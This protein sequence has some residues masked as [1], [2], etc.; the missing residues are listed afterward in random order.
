MRIIKQKRTV[1]PIKMVGSTV[2]GRYPKISKE[3]TFNMIISDGWLVPY[4]GHKKVAEIIEGGEARGL[5]NSIPLGKMVIVIDN[6]IYFYSKD[7]ALEFRGNID[8]YTSDVFIAENDANQIAICD[9]KDI[10][11]LDYKN[12]TFSKAYT[13]PETTLDFVPNYITFQ[14]GYFIAAEATRSRWRLSKINDGREFPAGAPYEGAFQSKSDIPLAVVSVPGKGNQIF[15]MGSSVTEAWVDTGAALF[16]YQK[17]TAFN[18]DYGCVNQTTIAAS[19]DFIV[20]VGINEK[21]GLAILYS[22]GGSVRQISNDGINFKLAELTNPADCYAFLFKQ[23]GHLLYQAVWRTDNISYV[24]DFNTEAFFTLTDYNYSHHIAKRVTFF[25]N[26]YYFISF[27][28]GALYELSSNYTDYDGKQIPRVRITPTIR[29]P[30]DSSFIGDYLTF[31]A[32]QGKNSELSAIDMSISRDGGNFFGN[33][34]RFELNKLGGRKNK[35]SVWNLGRANEMTFRFQFSGNGRF[36]LN[37]GL[38]EA[39]Q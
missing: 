16:P 27:K 14:N 25:N 33:D 36:V 26:K 34:Y 13:S 22:T 28:D 24:Y 2:F 7:G 29:I 39:H 17:T 35:L 18:I 9:K 30:D 10:Y 37:N 32:E 4:A 38:M 15:V 11:I 31:L 1:F 19:G 21:S 8:T 20:W 3:E 23:D 5:F 12:N 6:N